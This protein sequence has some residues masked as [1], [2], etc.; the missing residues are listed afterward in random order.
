MEENKIEHPLSDSNVNSVGNISTEDVN[1]AVNEVE[2][3]NTMVNITDGD[4]KDQDQ[5]LMELLSD[6]NVM[7]AYRKAMKKYRTGQ[8]G[9]RQQVSRKEYKKKKAKRRM[10]KKSK[11]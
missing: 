5:E 6:A 11:K 2:S 7:K 3:N 1:Q 4:V 10:A 8:A 9:E